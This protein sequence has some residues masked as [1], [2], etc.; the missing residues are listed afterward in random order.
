MASPSARIR[1]GD[2]VLIVNDASPFPRRLGRDRDTA[3][4][5]PLPSRS[6]LRGQK[7]ALIA[8]TSQRRHLIVFKTREAHFLSGNLRIRPSDTHSATSPPRIE[9]SLQT[10]HCCLHP[11]TNLLP[12]TSAS[13]SVRSQVGKRLVV[14]VLVV[15]ASPFPRRLGRDCIDRLPGLTQKSLQ[16]S[17]AQSMFLA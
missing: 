4:Q 15:D 14:L 13:P 17:W 16:T 12:A 9:P 1:A 8:H 3:W 2:R 7:A 5:D 6:R 11:S 10:A